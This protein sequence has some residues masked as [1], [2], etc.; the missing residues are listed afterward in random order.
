MKKCCSRVYNFF[1][2]HNQSPYMILFLIGACAAFAY[3]A[4]LCSR[5]TKEKR[6]DIKNTNSNYF[7]KKASQVTR[8][9]TEKM[10][11]KED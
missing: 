4:I 6:Q 10:P 11:K 7:N 1:E 3:L 2:K 9:V 5:K 8:K